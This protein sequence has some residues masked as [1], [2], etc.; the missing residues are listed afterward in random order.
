MP[1]IGLSETSSASDWVSDSAAGMTAIVTGEKTDN[2]VLS[3]TAQGPGAD[4]IRGYLLN[5]DLFHI[6]L[7]AYGWEPPRAD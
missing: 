2:G 6:M 7:T 1:H 5:T 4:A 3:M